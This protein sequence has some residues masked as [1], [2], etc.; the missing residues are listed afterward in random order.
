MTSLANWKSTIPCA[1]IARLH[2][3]YCLCNVVYMNKQF[4]GT[5]SA[6]LPGDEVAVSNAWRPDPCRTPTWSWETQLLLALTGD[7]PGFEWNKC[8]YVSPRS[9]LVKVET[10]PRTTTDFEDIIQ[11]NKIDLHLTG[12]KIEDHF[13]SSYQV[14]KNV[15][16][17]VFLV[18]DV[19]GNRILDNFFV[20]DVISKHD[21]FIW[22]FFLLCRRL[23]SVW[24]ADVEE[25]IVLRIVGAA[26]PCCG[27]LR[28][29]E[30]KQ[31]IINFL[32]LQFVSSVSLIWK[33]L[34]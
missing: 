15:G 1:E 29:E 32:L 18:R 13:L 31:K 12:F 28:T 33:G 25:G 7:D 8:E 17:R 6:Y 3:V 5:E 22:R 24:E 4:A 2:C 23:T 11:R 34:T 30:N 19:T 27:W 10:E 16:P 26:D 14:W 9:Y 20:S 21:N